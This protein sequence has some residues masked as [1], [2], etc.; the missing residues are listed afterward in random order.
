MAF[1]HQTLLL[2]GNAAMLLSLN[3]KGEFCLYARRGE[4][5]RIAGLS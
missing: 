2:Y 5:I 1:F 3:T 4:K